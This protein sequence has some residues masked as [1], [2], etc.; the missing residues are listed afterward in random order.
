MFNVL[1]LLIGLMP[2]G[3]GILI[4]IYY[5]NILR[6]GEFY[7]LYVSHLAIQLTLLRLMR[8]LPPNI[9]DQGVRRFLIGFI[10][11]IRR[12]WWALIMYLHF[13]LSHPWGLLGAKFFS[14]LF[15]EFQRF[16]PLQLY[17]LKLIIFKNEGK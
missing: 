3:N 16:I 17:T 15:G 6:I 11:S 12:K 2:V 9:D 1:L 13:F 7:A 8:V 14:E 10:H 5:G 4:H